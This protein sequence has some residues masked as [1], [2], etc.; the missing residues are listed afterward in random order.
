MIQ[1]VVSTATALF[2]AGTMFFLP[3]DA[4][5]GWQRGLSLFV[6]GDLVTHISY[7]VHD[8]PLPADFSS[9][10]LSLLILL[11]LL[12]ILAAALG[13]I[14]SALK[15]GFRVAKV[16]RIGGSYYLAYVL[17][18]YGVGK[19]LGLQFYIPEANVLFTPFGQLTKDIL[20]WSTVGTSHSFNVVTG[21]IECA[22]ALLLL[23]G[24]TRV[25]GLFLCLFVL[26]GIV[27]L[28]FTFDISVKLFSL[29]LTA[30]NLFCLW[31]VLP[32]LGRFFAGKGVV[33]LNGLFPQWSIRSV[34]T[35][36]Q[37]VFLASTIVV[38]AIWQQLP[39]DRHRAFPNG[40][41][42]V[43]SGVASRPGSIRRFFVHS[44]DYLILQDTTGSLV[45]YHFEVVGPAI[46]VEDYAGKKTVG[47]FQFSRKDSLLRLEVPERGWLF[48]GKAIDIR[49]LPALQDDTHFLLDDFE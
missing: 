32:A 20:F 6:F 3:F 23:L 17:L 42:E 2:F 28:N 27:L 48:N 35:L 43:V 37:Q 14:L 19:I 21:I 22:I 16:V 12:A 7:F 34:W 49:K 8:H 47:R 24:R 41:Y 11:G 38:T 18:C 36:W 15:T 26:L 10:T 31:P 5:E 39:T 45:D 4:G 1:R 13:W 46:L 9:D 33:S 29:L 44:H 30:L 25:L 40:A